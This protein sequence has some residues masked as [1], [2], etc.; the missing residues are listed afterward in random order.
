MASCVFNTLLPIYMVT[1]LRMSMRSMGMFEGLLEAFSYVVR[2]F[3]GVFTV[4]H[5]LAR[6]PSAVLWMF[7]CAFE[8]SRQRGAVLVDEEREL[9]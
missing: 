4:L 8:R 6:T 1:E 3:S 7:W 9:S 5:T 2:M